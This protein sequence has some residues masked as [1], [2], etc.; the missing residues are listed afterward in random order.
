[1]TTATGSLA[2]PEIL[3][4]SGSSGASAVLSPTKKQ[5]A[6]PALFGALVATS[7]NVTLHNATEI[8]VNSSSSGISVVSSAER[9]RRYEVDLAAVQVAE[10]ELQLAQARLNRVVSRDQLSAGSQTGSVGRLADVSSEV[11]LPTPV[12]RPPESSVLPAQ[13]GYLNRRR[14]RRSLT[15]SLSSTMR[16][17]LGCNLQVRS[18][19]SMAP[20]LLQWQSELPH[21]SRNSSSRLPPPLSPASPTV[22]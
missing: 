13:R 21:L 15:H 22:S 1:M 14:P 11:G 4:I 8:A 20:L 9:R 17:P 3:N 19:D 6:T 12:D 5:K 2:Q 10:L 7:E 16:Q 18:S